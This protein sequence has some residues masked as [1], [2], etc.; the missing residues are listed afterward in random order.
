MELKDFNMKFVKGWTKGTKKL[1]KQSEIK[2]VQHCPR[3]DEISL[4]ELRKLF[5]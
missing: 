1:L 2:R 3:F 4:P 5:V